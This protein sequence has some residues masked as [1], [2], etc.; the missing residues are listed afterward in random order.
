MSGNSVRL[1]AGKGEGV[2]DISNAINSALFETADKS[3]KVEIASSVDKRHSPSDVH[4]N[5]L[6]KGSAL[7]F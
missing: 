3:V 5:S 6:T 7:G 2:S 4:A 1:V